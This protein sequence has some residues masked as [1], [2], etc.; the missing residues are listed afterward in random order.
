M[1]NFNVPQSIKIERL[2]ICKKCKWYDEKTV[3]LGKT[4]WCGTAVIGKTV[5]PEE[6]Y[7]TYY[8]EKIKLCGCH[9]PTKTMFRFTS[10]PAHKWHALDWSQ[11]EIQQLDEFINRLGNPHKIEGED[12][13]ELFAWFSKITKK[14][15]QVSQCASCIKELIKEFR[16]QLGKLNE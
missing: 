13:A 8:K 1:F 2:N 7:V 15:Q 3:I 5:D 11:R 16:R 6:N 14:P 10:C 4:G 12:A 9:M